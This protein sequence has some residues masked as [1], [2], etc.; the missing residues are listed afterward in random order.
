MSSLSGAAESDSCSLRER[1][2][3]DTVNKVSFLIGFTFA[4]SV[5]VKTFLLEF[6]RNSF[7]PQDDVTAPAPKEAQQEEYPAKAAYNKIQLTQP[8]AQTAAQTEAEA[9]AEELVF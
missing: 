8:V 3:G 2:K 6:I 4:E 1:Q 5:L 7:Y 9:Q